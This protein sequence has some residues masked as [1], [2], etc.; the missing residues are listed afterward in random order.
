MGSFVARKV[1]IASRNTLPMEPRTF[2]AVSLR[3]LFSIFLSRLRISAAV[4]SVIGRFASG[5][6][7][8]SR[9][10]RFFVIVDF[11]VPLSSKFFKCSSARARKVFFAADC[12]AILSSFF[13]REGS[14]PLA[15][16]F[17]ASSLLARASAREISGNEPRLS[18]FCLPPK[19]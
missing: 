4:I 17:R 10:Q 14:M 5:E 15:S 19:R 8:S 16:S 18:M 1:V 9:Y 7:R 12:A 13:C 3:P 11:A 6:A 2:R